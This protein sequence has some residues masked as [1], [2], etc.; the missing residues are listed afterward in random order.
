MKKLI[1]IL[2]ISL[3]TLNLYSQTVKKEYYDYRQTQ[4]MA[5]YQVNS[6]GEKHG[7]FKGYDQQGVVVYEFNYK[8]NLFNG[9]NK[10]YSTSN[11]SRQLTKS[12]TYKDGVLNGPAIYYSGFGVIVNQG[13]YIDG[14]ENGKW[15]VLKLFSIYNNSLY[16]SLSKEDQQK[17]TYVGGYYNYVEGQV[18]YPDGESKFY[19]YPSEKIYAIENYQGG[20]KSGDCI[21]YKPDGSILGEQH[22][23]TAEDI[24]AKKKNELEIIDSALTALKKHEFD[25]AASYFEKINSTTDVDIMNKLSKAKKLQKEKN[26]YYSLVEIKNALKGIQ[27]PIISDYYNE[28][29][30][31]LVLELNDEIEK[32]AKN[33]DVEG[34]KNL[35]KSYSNVLTNDNKTK[36]ELLISK[37]QVEFQEAIAIETKGFLLY[38]NYIKGNVVQKQTLFVDAD[39]K[40]IMKDDYPR[41]EFLYLKSKLII[42]KYRMNFLQE[43]ENKKRN[44]L[45][46]KFIETIEKLNLLP[47]N[48]WK[49]LNKQLKKVDDPE[50]IKAILKI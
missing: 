24:E 9:I 12:E 28:V 29:Y 42:D 11:G 18:V 50:Q 3:L 6:V 19:Y 15:L 4:I 34:M 8:N 33:L 22:F 48:E 49:D 17:Y 39:G 36:Y 25:V 32:F 47:E 16:Y 37:T 38:D 5:Q 35:L 45:G 46:D 41:G 23:D 21:Y 27:N 43:L 2:I 7:W 44:E 31:L 20:K 30:N 10:E 1:A 14:K 40:P 13:N 26:Y